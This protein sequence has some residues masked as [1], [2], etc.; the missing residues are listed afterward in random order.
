MRVNSSCPSCRRIGMCGYI[1]REK[2]K[3]AIPMR[4]IVLVV[5]ASVLWFRADASAIDLEADLTNDLD[6]D[7]SDPTGPGTPPSPPLPILEQPETQPGTI[8]TPPAPPLGP[9]PGPPPG[10]PPPVAN[11]QGFPQGMNCPSGTTWLSGKCAPIWPLPGQPPLV[12]TEKGPPPAVNCP[13]GMISLSGQCVPIS[14]P[15]LP[16]LK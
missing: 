16:P 9:R 7:A 14:L 12:T 3:N 15:R 5:C 6:L 1:S 2:F 11:P 10:M 8:V 4:L 13:P